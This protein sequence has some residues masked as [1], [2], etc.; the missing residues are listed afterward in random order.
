MPSVE[1]DVLRAALAELYDNIPAIGHHELEK[2]VPF[3][4]CPKRDL[5]KAMNMVAD[6]LGK[7]RPYPKV[8]D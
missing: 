7:P 8:A 4:P 2:E 6:L 5:A 1:A 3:Y